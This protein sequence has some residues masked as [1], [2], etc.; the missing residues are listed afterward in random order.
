LPTSGTIYVR[1]YSKIDGEWLWSDY[2]FTGAVPAASFSTDTVFFSGQLVGATSQKQNI[3]MLNRGAT[4]LTVHSVDFVGRDAAQFSQTN[5]CST[6]APGGFC[7][8]WVAFTPTSEGGKSASLVVSHNSTGSPGTVSVIGNSISPAK[9]TLKSPVPGST[10]GGTVT[11]EWASGIG[12]TS[13]WLE[14]GTEGVGSKNLFNGGVVGTSKTVEGLPTTGTIYV[15]LYSKIGDEWQWSD[16]TFQGGVSPLTVVGLSSGV[17]F[18]TVTNTGSGVLNISNV[19]L[20]GADSQQFSQ[21]NTCANVASGSSCEI[22]VTFRPTSAGNK[23]SLIAI[24]HNASG[25]PSTVLVTGSAIPA[26]KAVLLSPTPSSTI[27]ASAAFQWTSGTGVSGYWLELGTEG[28]GTKNLYN[29]GVTGTAVN[30]SGLPTSGTIYVRLYS[31]IGDDWLWN[32]YTLTGS[33]KAMLVSPALGSRISGTVNFRWTSGTGVSGYWFEVGTSG[34]GSKNLYNS[35]VSSTSA[36]VSGLPTS[37]TI[38]VRLYSK[39]GDDWQW[40]DYRF[41]NSSPTIVVNP[42]AVSF[43]QTVGTTSTT[44][45]ISVSTSNNSLFGVTVR[46]LGP[47]ENQFVRRFSTCSGIVVSGSCSIDIAFSPTTIGRKSAFLEIVTSLSGNPI[48]VDLSG[49][50]VAPQVVTGSLAAACIGASCGAL[51][52]TTYAGSGVGVWG[53]TNTSSNPAKVNV[54]LTGVKGGNKV[55]LVFSNGGKAT[56]PTVPGFGVIPGSTASQDM[57]SQSTA[58]AP[59]ESASDPRDVAHSKILESNREMISVLRASRSSRI[60]VDSELSFSG[61]LEISVAPTIGSQRIW[62]DD[63]FGGV[64]YKTSARAT[65][66][67]LSGRVIVFWIDDF[68]WNGRVTSSIVEKFKNAYCGTT[69]AYERLVKLYGEPWGAHPYSNL[70]SDAPTLQNLNVVMVSSSAGYGGYFWGVNAYKEANSQSSNGALAFFINVSGFRGDSTPLST[71]NYYISTLVHEMV[72]MVNFYQRGVR[73]GEY[74]DTWL[75]ETSAMASEDIITPAVIEY[76]GIEAERI[77]PY[78]RSGGNVSYINWQRLSNNSYAIGGSFA[79]FMNRR[80]GLNFFKALQTCPSDSYSCVDSFINL[81]GG[82]SFASEFA[83]MG[84]SVFSRMPSSG[85]PAQYGFPMRVDGEYRLNAIDVSAF[86]GPSSGA[87]VSAGYLATSQT[88]IADTV[89]AGKSSYVRNEVLVPAGTSLTVIV[90]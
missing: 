47:D 74:H 77:A 79:A 60:F 41:D 38:Y 3:G 19:T 10:I 80:Y 63:A 9:A 84:A 29:R 72:H 1:L 73:R 53:Y 25:A 13:Y 52:S 89:V 65:C 85:L 75:E 30:L 46:L 66:R 7:N 59:A 4:T 88:F 37:G 17:A 67:A 57:P 35:A 69:G 40:N 14:V 62:K 15:R 5:T 61:P 58:L 51:D 83:R 54:A 78:L 16:F 90:Q 36:T 21:V 81:N 42:T 45:S 82:G 43:S 55:T 12:V 27:G 50:A 28:I 26:V 23:S 33:A 18:I 32:D 71:T 86:T 39:I 20:T 56:A 24:S 76:T 87:S 31:K 22:R 64:Y 48:I 44:Q 2:T 70:I 68:A 11:F 34:V 8:L 49:T 6:L